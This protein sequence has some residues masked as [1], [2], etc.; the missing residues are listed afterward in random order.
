MNN[1]VIHAYLFVYIH[2]RK[3]RIRFLNKIELIEDRNHRMIS[4]PLFDLLFFVLL[5]TVD[6]LYPLMV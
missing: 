6:I 3:S 5:I 4:L 2:N 1:M